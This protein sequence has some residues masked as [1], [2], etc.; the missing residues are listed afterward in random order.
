MPAS[1]LKPD[2]NFLIGL[3]LFEPYLLPGTGPFGWPRESF[4]SFS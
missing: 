4:S 1:F 3:F 2:K